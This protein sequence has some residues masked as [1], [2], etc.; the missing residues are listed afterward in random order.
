[1][2]VAE[3]IIKALENEGVEYVFG[4]PGE[5]TQDLLF[6]LEFSSITFIP[7]RHEQGAAF[8]ADAYGRSTGKAGVCLATLGPGATNLVTGI[9]D[10]FLDKVP[11]VAI[12][13][14][15]SSERVHKESHQ[16]LD[17]V[18]MLKPLTKWNT[19]IQNPRTAS[20]VVRKAFKIAQSE[21]P[22]PTHIELP[23]DI[24]ALKVDVPL[25][26]P[27]NP[28]RSAPDHKAID[29]AVDLLKNAQAPV[30]L[31]GNGAIR[32]MASKQ[33]RSFVE[34]TDIPV[35]ST[36]MGKGAI[37]DRDRHSLYTIGIQGRD[38]QMCALERSDLI[39]AI[40]Y[41]IGEYEPNKWNPMGKKDI[42]HI[43]F[44]PAEVNKY[45]QAK[46]EIIADISATLWELCQHADAQSLKFHPSWFASLR[47]EIEA[48]HQ[49]YAL[50]EGELFTVPGSLQIIR[51]FMRAGDIM[52]SDVGSHKMWIG[53]NFPV[54]K[55][56]STFI[57]NGLATMGIALPGGIGAKLAHPSKRV[58]T[59]MGDGGFLMNVQEIET[60]KRIGLGFPIIVFNDNDYGLI[61]WKQASSS[62][63]NFG[64]TLTNPNF[65]DL[66]KSFGIEGYAPK[67]LAELRQVLKRVIE[68]Q[69]LSI[70]EIPI[71]PRVNNELTE[72]LNK[73]ICEL[74]EFPE[75]EKE[76]SS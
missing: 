9:G 65:V 52:L 7:T 41:D 34:K 66:A 36:F 32:K 39:L 60:A 12:T 53:R 15:G 14:Q 44:E 62:G 64:T 27:V 10:A 16:V 13:A 18:R 26:K 17:I 59:A 22:G 1:M 42:I 37:D 71:D 49:S 29:A 51:E 55:P 56:N 72:K 19:S 23:E 25:L 24:A 46:I 2:T 63:K 38:Y 4:V 76:G 70:I 67:T 43:D 6:A 20:E 35:I 11:L 40:G 45:Y 74:F 75:L 48:D 5:E 61:R 57:S 33:L 31:A 58:V 68:D 73:N 3:L 30:I 47:K 28:R 8:M 69:V 50:K 21:K 54:Y